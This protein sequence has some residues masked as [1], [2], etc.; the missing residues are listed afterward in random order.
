MKNYVNELITVPLPEKLS[1]YQVPTYE[2]INSVLIYVS[3]SIDVVFNAISINY[4]LTIRG[5]KSWTFDGNELEKLNAPV[6]FNIIN[7]N[8]LNP[9]NNVSVFIKRYIDKNE[10]LQN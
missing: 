5:G 3:G 10:K 7:N 8:P 2:N 4:N 6:I 9:N 1:S